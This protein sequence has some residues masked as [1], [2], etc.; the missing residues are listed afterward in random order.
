MKRLMILVMGLF[1][2]PAML[3]AEQ[4]DTVWVRRAGSA[5]HDEPRSLALIDGET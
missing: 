5:G 2:L 3:V 4:A 1:L